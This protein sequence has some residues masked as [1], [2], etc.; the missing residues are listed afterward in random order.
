MQF[1][2]AALA[3]HSVA[4]T[5]PAQPG[6]PAR[7]HSAAMVACPK[8]VRSS[9]RPL[10]SQQSV[11]MCVCVRGSMLCFYVAIA[12]VCLC[13]SLAPVLECIK[14]FWHVLVVIP[15]PE[16]PPSKHGCREDHFFSEDSS[17]TTWLMWCTL[18]EC[19]HASSGHCPHMYMYTPLLQ[20][21]VRSRHWTCRA[22]AWPA[23]RLQS[24]A[25]AVRARVRRPPS[26]GCQPAVRATARA[27][28][29]AAKEG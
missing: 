19:P 2:L 11:H 12:C 27:C 4:A 24:Q 18:L 3:R 16:A 23:R 1:K 14:R 7:V 13:T 29:R 8:P 5:D 6:L 25:H 22:C 26:P 10:H 9:A 17:R 15:Q 20:A 28:C 21:P